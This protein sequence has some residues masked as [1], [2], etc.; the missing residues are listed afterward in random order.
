MVFK[1]IWRIINQLGGK[2]M[3][4]LKLLFGVMLLAALMSMSA[5]AYT[6]VNR[7]VT[8]QNI[9]QPGGTPQPVYNATLWAFT[10]S[11]GACAN[12]DGFNPLGAHDIN[13][14]SIE[15]NMTIQEREFCHPTLNNTLVEFAC[16]SSIRVNG[17]PGKQF[18][19]HPGLFLFDCQSIGKVCSKDRCV[20]PGFMPLQKYQSFRSLSS[21][22]R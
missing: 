20:Q 3:K 6:W 10:T 19:R 7:T 9:W 21:K 18:P 16:P 11:S 5:S 1:N 12:T 17:I 2:T 13:F 15:E 22:R 14:F 4:H 8:V